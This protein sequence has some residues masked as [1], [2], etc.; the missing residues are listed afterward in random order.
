[1]AWQPDQYL[2][3]A[4]ERLRPALDLI[5]RID[6]DA[7]ARIADLGC[8][9]GNVTRLL[10]LRWPSASLT[11]VDS[12]LAMLERAQ[13]VLPEACW[14]EADVSSWMPEEPLDL[15]FSNA[16]LHWIDNQEEVLVRMVEAL[17]PG[18]VL[19]VQMPGN[20]NAPS[21]TLIRQLA[22]RE[23][24]AQ[25]LAEA[26]MGAVREMAAYH[27]LLAPRVSHLSMWGTTY[28][29]AMRG[30]RPVLEWLRG[31]TLVPYLS[32]LAEDEQTAFLEELQVGL[33]KAYP[34]DASGVTLFPFRR[35]FL[36]ASR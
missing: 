24:W 6:L 28:W 33:A 18:G 35:I 8:G 2:K 26:Q 14:V 30:E 21:H 31:T 16:A 15:V 25:K 27:S 34:A 9:A 20:F 19:A 29:Q 32:R 12:S 11:G 23:P 5:G 22:S 13:S 1:M 7:P 10:A 36:L 4:D 17:V 3:F